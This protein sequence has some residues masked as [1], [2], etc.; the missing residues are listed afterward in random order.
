MAVREPRGDAVADALKRPMQV[1]DITTQ[2]RKSGKPRRIEIVLHN[3]DGRLYLSGQPRPERRSWLA[4]LDGNPRFTL[5]LKQGVGADL[6]A[7]AREITD[8][9]ERRQV[10]EG[11]A[12]HWKRTDVDTMVQQ[13]PLIE[14]TLQH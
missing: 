12:R 3:I 11:V 9:K 8:S 13:S 14:V 4:N 2:G 1:V 7:T 5:H 10:L 6:Q